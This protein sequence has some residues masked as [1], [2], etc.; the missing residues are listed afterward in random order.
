MLTPKV[1]LDQTFPQFMAGVKNGLQQLPLAG[2]VQ[3]G[4]SGQSFIKLLPSYLQNAVEGGA[5]VI[6]DSSLCDQNSSS[7]SLQDSKQ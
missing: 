6:Y 2:K 4:R 5:S 3:C 7:I 1:C